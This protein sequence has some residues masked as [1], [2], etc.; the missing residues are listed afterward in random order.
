MLRFK[1][2]PKMGRHYFTGVS[3]ETGKRYTREIKPGDIIRCES[4][5]LRGA[6]DKFECLEPDELK[7]EQ[8]RFAKVGLKVIKIGRGV[9]DVVNEVTN[10]IINDVPLTLEE[11][12]SIAMAGIKEEE[13]KEEEAVVVE[14][15]E[16]KEEEEEEKPVKKIKRKRIKKKREN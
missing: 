5:K 8:Q 4:H 16:V 1:M 2:L 7:K 15:E 12:N 13:G 9:Y 10:N 6:M 3:E 11:A 14:E